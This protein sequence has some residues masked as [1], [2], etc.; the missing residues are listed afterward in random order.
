[1]PS[2]NQYGKLPAQKASGT[3][4][5]HYEKPPAPQSAIHPKKITRTPKGGA[6]KG[7]V[8]PK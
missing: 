6:I 1:V 7:P 5:S 3:T 4:T 2:N 8:K